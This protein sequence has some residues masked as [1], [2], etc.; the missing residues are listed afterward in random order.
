[1]QETV[2]SSTATDWREGRRLR[3]WELIQQ[4]WS[5]REAAEAVGV[6]EGAVS[7]WVRR[8][9]EGGGPEA[10]LSRKAPGGK[11]RLSA[12]QRER[13]PKLLERGAEAWGFR[14]ALWTRRRVA[15]VIRREFGISYHPSHVGRL[16]RDCGW[17][18]QKPVRRAQQRNEETI[19]TW[20][21]ERWPEV[22]KGGSKRGVPSP[23]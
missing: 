7:Q 18:V 19:R 1:M 13:V 21:A 3:A 12:E 22:K 23:T 17:T 2:S 16:L 11:P 14:G 4:G 9:R 15:E 5:Q 6:T 10:L 20:A 8:A